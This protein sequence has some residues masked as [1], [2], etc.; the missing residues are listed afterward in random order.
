ML[1]FKSPRIVFILENRADP[2]E[3][4]RSVAFHLGLTVFK[5]PRIQRVNGRY[6]PSIGVYIGKHWRQTCV[7]SE[8]G[9][10]AAQTKVF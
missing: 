10:I 9:K 7:S 4:P 3:M 1:S 6:M 5:V 8:I 2:D